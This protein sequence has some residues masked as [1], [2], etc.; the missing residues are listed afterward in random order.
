[1]WAIVHAFISTLHQIYPPVLNET[2]ILPSLCVLQCN[3]PMAALCP[4]GFQLVHA[5]T[6]TSFPP[7]SAHLCNRSELHIHT[8]LFCSTIWILINQWLTDCRSFPPVLATT[9]YSQ[10]FSCRKIFV[11]FM[12]HFLKCNPLDMCIYINVSSLSTMEWEDM[13]C[14]HQAHRVSHDFME[15]HLNHN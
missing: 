10:Q 3:G 5:S 7:H 15:Y 11:T 13:H 12:L 6:Q 14:F 9:F 1:M 4:G 8:L 2:L